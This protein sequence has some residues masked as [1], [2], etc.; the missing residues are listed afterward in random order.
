MLSLD[1]SGAYDNIPHECLLYIFRT[2][3]FPKWIIQFVQG[4]T[5]QKETLLVFNG[6]QSPPITVITGIPQG[7]PLSPILFLFFMSNL[8]N[9]FEEGAT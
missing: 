4:F 1:I 8:L 3:G 6:Y 5:G 9:T 2:K 7:L